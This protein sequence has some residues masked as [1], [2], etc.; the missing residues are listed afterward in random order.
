VTYDNADRAVKVTPSTFDGRTGL[1]QDIVAFDV[2]KILGSDFSDEL[3]SL[4]SNTTLNGGR[5]DDLLTGGS[6]PSSVTTFDMGRRADG[7][8]RHL[9]LGGI[10][11]IDYSQ[12]T[13]P[14]TVTPGNGKLDDGEAGEGDSIAATGSLIV[15]GGSAGDVISMVAVPGNHSLHGNGGDDRVEGSDLGEFVGGGPGVDTLI[16][17]GGDDQVDARDGVSDIVGCGAGT[18]DFAS[19]DAN[20]VFSSCENRRVGVLRLAPKAVQAKAGEVAQVALSW[21]HPK[22][23]KQLRAIELRL[24]RDGAPVGSVAIDPHDGK[25]KA[26]GAVKV[27]RRAS[28]LRRDGRTVRAR[29]AIRIDGSLA[30]ATLKAEVE[31]TDR[32][33]SRQL[34]RN[35][36]TIRVTE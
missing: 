10:T 8:D 29:L 13:A 28:R 27:A 16:A 32:R 35:A 5:G 3:T 24:T 22:A 1:D 12:R 26:V 15:D 9:A 31:A 20:D 18:G 25:I 23:W 4:G 34:E 2:E 11:R 36:G 6:A 17:N 19:L 30:G 14:V 7:A 21:R 33:G